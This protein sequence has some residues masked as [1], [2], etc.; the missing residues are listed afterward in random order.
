MLGAHN[1]PL[2][3]FLAKANTVVRQVFGGQ[4]T[5]ASA[6]IEAVDWGVFD[7]VCLDYYRGARNRDS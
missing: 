2:N 5:Y 7:F 3:A 6:P 1:R 4:V